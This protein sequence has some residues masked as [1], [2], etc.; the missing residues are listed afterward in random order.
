MDGRRPPRPPG[1]HLGPS[2]V[3]DALRRT[4]VVP[5]GVGP[6]RLFELDPGR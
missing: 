3:R 2:T 1:G 4:D 6:G 5:V